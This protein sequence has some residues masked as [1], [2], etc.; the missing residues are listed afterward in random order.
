M[1][2]RAGPDATEKRKMLIFNMAATAA[3]SVMH[4]AVHKLRN[5]TDM[6]EH[7]EHLYASVLST[8]CV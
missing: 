5:K 4:H 3:V 1:D 6:L 2:S 7:M 8:E